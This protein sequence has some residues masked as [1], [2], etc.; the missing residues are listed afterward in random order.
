MGGG[1]VAPTVGTATSTTLLASSAS[2]SKVAVALVE[3]SIIHSLMLAAVG[4]EGAVGGTC[5]IVEQL[6]HSA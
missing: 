6:L 2:S 3:A 5:P 4:T 1:I